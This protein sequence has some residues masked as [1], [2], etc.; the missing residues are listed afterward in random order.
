MQTHTDPAA[1]RNS[2]VERLDRFLA[3]RNPG[4]A[5]M[6]AP[7]ALRMRNTVASG[8]H[9]TDD[10]LLQLRAWLRTAAADEAIGVEIEDFMA[11]YGAIRRVTDLAQAQ[12]R[13]QD[14]ATRKSADDLDRWLRQN[15]DA[16]G[17]FVESVRAIRVRID[18]GERLR[19][20][21]V[22]VVRRCQRRPFRR[23]RRRLPVGAWAS[24]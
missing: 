11:S 13:E 9:L 22:T 23:Q 21:D 5:A 17:A 18:N 16:R 6:L 24:P 4:V 8:G 14:A 7:D 12:H 1:L 20:E 2:V 3:T 19:D 10:E 15:P